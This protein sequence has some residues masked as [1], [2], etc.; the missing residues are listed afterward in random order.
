[1]MSALQQLTLEV[2]L[3]IFLELFSLLQRC[4]FGCVTTS[5]ASLMVV[6]QSPSILCLYRLAR[7]NNCSTFRLRQAM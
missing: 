5:A 7:W 4:L 3:D 2:V 1:M 6:N